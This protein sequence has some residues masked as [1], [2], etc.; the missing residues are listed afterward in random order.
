MEIIH[1]RVVVQ[2]DGSVHIN[3]LPFLPGEEVE[4]TVMAQLRTSQSSI[5]TPLDG[6]VLKYIDPTGPVAEDDWEAI[7]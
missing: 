1:V 6:S 7:K 5:Q 3:D 4:V 2:P